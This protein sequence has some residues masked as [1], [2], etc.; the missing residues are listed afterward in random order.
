MLTFQATILTAAF[1]VYSEPGHAGFGK[2]DA[3]LT[4]SV[5]SLFEDKWS[6]L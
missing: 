2:D 3:S 1:V 4:H 6:W 5:A